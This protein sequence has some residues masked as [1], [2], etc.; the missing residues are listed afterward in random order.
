MECAL[1][2]RRIVHKAYSQSHNSEHYGNLDI[3]SDS[4]IKTETETFCYVVVFGAVGA[5]V[6]IVAI[7]CPLLMI[8]K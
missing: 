7:H 5:I 2:K 3:D 4:R 8:S 6:V 1:V